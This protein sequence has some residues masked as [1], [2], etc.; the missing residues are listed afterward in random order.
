[1]AKKPFS[2]RPPGQKA[3][4][5]VLAAISLAIIATAERDIQGRTEDEIRGSR[6]MWRVLSLNALGALAYLRFA[7]R[8]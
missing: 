7:R 8:A 2:E 3:V 1:M 4:L 5:L 6:T